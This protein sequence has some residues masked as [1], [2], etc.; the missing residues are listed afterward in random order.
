M[1]SG[2]LAIKLKKNFRNLRKSINFAVKF[3]RVIHQN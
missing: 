1:I 2:N 3:K